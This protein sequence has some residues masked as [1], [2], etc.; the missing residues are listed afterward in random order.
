MSGIVAQN[1]GRQSGLVKPVTGGGEWT[2]IQTLTSDGS[3]ATI[4][5]TSGLDDTYDEY[6]FKYINIHPETDDSEFQFQATTDGSNFN[7]TSTS[8]HFTANH[9]EADTAT[10]LAYKT[11][12]DTAQATGFLNAGLNVGAD[13]DQ[14]ASGWL[15]V[16]NPASTTFVKHFMLQSNSSGQGNY[17]RVGFAAGYWNTT[18]AVTGIQWKFS[19]DEIQAGSISLYGIG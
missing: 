18:D 5:F 2:L 3:D 1:V 17:S 12:R 16:F 15:Y 11:D 14:N 9:D 10:Q 7:V 6:C 4:S 8:T 13:A 19:A